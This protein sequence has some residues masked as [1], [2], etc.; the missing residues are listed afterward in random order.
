M[1]ALVRHATAAV[2]ATWFCGWTAAAF[3]QCESL[4][5]ESNTYTVCAA[6]QKRTELRVF[7]RDRSGENYGSFSNLRRDLEKR[8]ETLIFAMNGGMYHPDLR[9]VG[10]YVENGQEISKISTRR[11]PGNFHL[12]PNGVFYVARDGAG[13]METRQYQRMRPAAIHATQSGPM[14]VVNGAIHP[15]FSVDSDSRKLR[16]GVG[17]CGGRMVFAI[18]EGGVTFHE[19][20]RLFRDRFKCANALFLDGSISA[21]Y[22]A[23]LNRNDGWRPMGPIVGLVEKKR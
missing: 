10:L 1:R 13:V 19:F 20:A 21:L 9:P 14:L 15:K 4:T 23:Q 7:L 11:G 5:F 22:S 3:A 12:Q 16:N 18:S 8:G 17:A 6:D 2:L